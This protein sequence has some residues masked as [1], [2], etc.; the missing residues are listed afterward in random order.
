MSQGFKTVVELVTCHV[1]EDPTS[2]GREQGG[3]HCGLHGI[4]RM[5]VRCAITLISPLSA[6]ILC[7]R[8][9][10]LDPLGDLAHSGFC[11]PM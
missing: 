10:P 5:R 7:S 3:I 11:D 4:L 8:I 6:A 1:P 9:A 2:A